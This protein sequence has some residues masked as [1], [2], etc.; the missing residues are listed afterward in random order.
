[1]EGKRATVRK[2]RGQEGMATGKIKILYCIILNTHIRTC[3]YFQ[4]I[5]FSGSLSP[6]S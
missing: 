2:E 5:V 3:N 1:M 6:I 4:N